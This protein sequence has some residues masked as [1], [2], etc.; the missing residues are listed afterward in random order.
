MLRHG[1]EPMHF[2]TG[3]ALYGDVGAKSAAVYTT[4]A[5]P[6][7][8]NLDLLYAAERAEGGASWRL[9]HVSLHDEDL[10]LERLAAAGGDADAARAIVRTMVDEGASLP[11]PAARDKLGRKR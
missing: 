9:T 2:T 6:R 5:T 1:E 11:L 7:G 3:G 8:R 10:K 4:A